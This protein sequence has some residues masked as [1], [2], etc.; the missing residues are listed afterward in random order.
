MWLAPS[1]S[2]ALGSGAAEITVPGSGSLK[3]PAA[4]K[5]IFLGNT[6]YQSTLA[7]TLRVWDPAL[8]TDGFP[9]RPS[10]VD[11]PLLVH[12]NVGPQYGRDRWGA[13]RLWRL[14]QVR[15][16]RTSGN[17]GRSLELEGGGASLGETLAALESRVKR[18]EERR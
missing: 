14:Q 2:S 10:T 17:L 8:T 15:Y 6:V 7:G 11:D 4:Y 5:D 1:V 12:T 3:I 13:T 9:A 18:T 16:R